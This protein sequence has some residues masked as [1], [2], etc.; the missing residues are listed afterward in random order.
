[1]ST[2]PD[3]SSAGPKRALTPTG[4]E[5][6][7]LVI[8][9][10]L[11]PVGLSGEVRAQILTDFPERF[12]ELQTVR[13]GDSLRPYRVLNARLDRGTALV[14]FAGID[15]ANAAQALT[16]E[17][18]QVPIDEAVSLPPDQYFWHQI[19]GLEVWTDDGRCLGRVTEVLQ[20][21]SNDVYV[22]G[23]GAREIL[24]PAIDEVVKNIDLASH[25]MTVHLLPGLE[26][27]RP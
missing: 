27:E 8:G 6:R 14:R 15:S 12:L 16:G 13:L 23:E 17:D 10:I 11:G 25:T 9:R 2:Q 4:H 3:S 19:I 26:E 21:G 7:F 1:V 24:I 18:I 22:V 20:T 5:V